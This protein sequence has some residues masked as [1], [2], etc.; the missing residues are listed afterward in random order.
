[1]GES[2]GKRMTELQGAVIIV[3]LAMIFAVLVWSMWL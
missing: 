3:Q 1:M 2:R